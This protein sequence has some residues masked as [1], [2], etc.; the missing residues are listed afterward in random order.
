[1]PGA[2]GAPLFLLHRHVLYKNP[3][4]NYYSNQDV[5]PRYI[6]KLITSVEKAEESCSRRRNM[7]L[8][9]KLTI[10]LLFLIFTTRKLTVETFWDVK[11]SA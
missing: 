8:S 2:P 1:M 3:I 10:R 9:H 7:T 5:A 11:N 4:R 6:Q